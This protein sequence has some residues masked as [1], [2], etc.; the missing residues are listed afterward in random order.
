MAKLQIEAFKQMRRSFLID[1]VTVVYRKD[2]R[3]RCSNSNQFK[4][5]KCD[6]HWF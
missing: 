4:V 2:M 6:I 5:D 1:I 3:R